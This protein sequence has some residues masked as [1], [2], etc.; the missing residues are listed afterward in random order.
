LKK[1]SCPGK[2]SIGWLL[3]LLQ[4]SKH[5]AQK[6]PDVHSLTPFLILH[7]QSVRRNDYSMKDNIYLNWI[8]GQ[9]EFLKLTPSVEGA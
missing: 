1:T 8:S 9:K 5:G 3:L 4:R 2:H 6:F 7:R